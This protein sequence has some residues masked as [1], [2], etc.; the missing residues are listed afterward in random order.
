MNLVLQVHNGCKRSV[1]TAFILL[2]V[3]RSAAVA[4]RPES[5]RQRPV[6]SDIQH[7]EPERPVSPTAE[8]REAVSFPLTDGRRLRGGRLFGW[9]C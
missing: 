6:E 1:A 8:P 9:W 3:M 7:V 4:R 5:Q 2:P